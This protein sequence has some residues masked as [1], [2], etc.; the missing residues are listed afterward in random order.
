MKFSYINSYSDSDQTDRVSNNSA[1]TVYTSL[2]LSSEQANSGT[3]KY[4]RCSCGLLNS[5]RTP[6]GKE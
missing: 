3:T 5:E 2:S 1:I 6:D 4:V